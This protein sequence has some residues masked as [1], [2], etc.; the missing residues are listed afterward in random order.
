[1]SALP[2][3][4]DDVFL[5]RLA[6]NRGLVS[7][8]EARALMADAAA[9][10]CTFLESAYGHSRITRDQA[11]ELHAELPRGDPAGSTVPGAGSRS[12]SASR[13]SGSRVGGSALPSPGAIIDGYEILR[14]LGEGGMGTV[15]L[16]RKYQGL[17]AIKVLQ[18][19]DAEALERFDREAKAIAAVGR[20]RNVVAVHAYTRDGP[21]PYVVL[22]YVEGSN[23]QEL[24][25]SMGEGA[26]LSADRALEIAIKMADALHTIHAAGILH[27]DLKP[28]NILIRREDGEPLLTDF[29]LARLAGARSLTQTQ[30]FLGTPQYAAPEQVVGQ[31]EDL[32]PHTDVWSLGVILYQLVTG[33]LPFEGENLT[34]ISA[35]ILNA[36]PRPPRE[37]RPGLD[38]ALSD[39]ILRALR[40]HPAERYRCGADLAE[41]GRAIREGRSLRR[42]RMEWI[43]RIPRRLVRKLGRATAIILTV[44]SLVALGAGAL[45]GAK[46]LADRQRARAVEAFRAEMDALLP[47]LKSSRERL[48]VHVGHHILR[49]GGVALADRADCHE[50]RALAR[51]LP[52]LSKQLDAE[53]RQP[54][55]EG[56]TSEVTR[57]R[58][59]G[60]LSEQASLLARLEGLGE[61]SLEPRGRQRVVSRIIEGVVALESGADAER[62]FA[63]SEVERDRR[64]AAIGA[65]GR[66]VSAMRREDWKRASLEIR[67]A[68]IPRLA[69]LIR[70]LEL[71]ARRRQLV[72]AIARGEAPEVTACYRSYEEC[73]AENEGEEAAWERVNAELAAHFKRDDVPAANLVGAYN[74]IESL[75]IECPRLAVPE[76]DARLHS[77]LGAAADR[78][79]D[80]A[81]AIYHY[82]Y[83]DRLEPGSSI[84]MGYRPK[85]LT[86]T[87]AY[88]LINVRG[89]LGGLE[90]FLEILVAASRAGLYMDYGR[91]MYSPRFHEAGLFD[92]RIQRAPSDPYGYFWRGT[93]TLRPQSRSEFLAIRGQVDGDLDRCLQSK[94]PD[95][96]K[97]VALK[98]RVELRAFDAAFGLLKESDYRAQAR[99]DLDLAIKLGHP[100]PDVIWE[101]L[102]QL[103]RD[104]EHEAKLDYL[105]RRERA[106]H[107]RHDRS[108]TNRLEEGRPWGCALT[109]LI[110]D[111]F[112]DKMISVCRERARVLLE[113]ERYEE[114]VASAKEG[115]GHFYRVV[116]METLRLLRRALRKLG[117]SEEIYEV[118][119][120][121]RRLS[122]GEKAWER[123]GEGSVD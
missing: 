37:L 80:K 22:D 11:V 104:D 2:S 121:L 59:W 4:P 85:D 69:P 7:F 91:K 78:A 79:G 28:A 96:F 14:V 52:R 5:A 75:L 105:A 6:V 108:L 83:V 76:V 122:N 111:E 34:E 84:P 107:D 41:D 87:M 88:A 86:V 67:L 43:G 60:A 70:P 73:L 48:R 46:L 68:R 109:V 16:A 63:H 24:L 61:E 110:D 36:Q 47:A 27:R 45:L 99:V 26:F 106:T 123:F 62:Q 81:E 44:A 35:R 120:P 74:L 9:R 19:L 112:R 12:G 10:G 82:L 116:N 57:S 100:A 97:A 1:M 31:S 38:R 8:E 20:H 65:L 40:K 3:K 64:W 51:A 103:C 54:G 119:R 118:V 95:Y 50:G 21:W 17:Y 56:L 72:A 94:I 55:L 25:R 102:F 71:L 114:S 39:L 66:A 53:E 98:S 42:S 77:A 32:G 30:Q 93:R 58:A 117:R 18:S 13:G 23:L 15:Y 49:A 101:S 115:V 89:G 90:E 113:L 92:R 29:G 33:E